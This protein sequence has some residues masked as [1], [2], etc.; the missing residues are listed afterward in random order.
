MNP[1]VICCSIKDALQYEKNNY[2]NHLPPE[3]D[4]SKNQIEKNLATIH[5][6]ALAHLIADILNPDPTKR[7][8]LE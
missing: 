1:C 4:A 5:P 8:T 2:E 6:P 3:I 7:P